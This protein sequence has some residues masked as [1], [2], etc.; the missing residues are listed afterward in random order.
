MDLLIRLREWGRRGGD[1]SATPTLPTAWLGAS[2]ADLLQRP[3]A[4]VVSKTRRFAGSLWVYPIH[5]RLWTGSIIWFD[6]PK[7]TLIM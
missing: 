4:R 2:A 6:K 3:D 1:V 5:T 7:Q